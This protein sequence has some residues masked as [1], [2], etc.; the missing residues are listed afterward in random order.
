M[1]DDAEAAEGGGDGGGCCRF[2]WQVLR[3]RWFMISA[4]F[5]VMCGAGTTYL[6][7]V[8]SKDIKVRLGYDQSTLNLL[9]S[10]KDLGSM[11]GIPAGLIAEIIPTWAVLLFGAVLNFSGYFVIWLAVVG[12][13]PKPAVWQM[14]LYICFGANSQNFT[15]TGGIVTC[16]KNFPEGRG[17]MMGLMKG[18]VGLSGALFTQIH[19]ALYGD[20][21]AS[22]ILLVAWLPPALALAFSSTVRPVKSSTHPRERRVFVHYMCVAIALAVFLMALIIAQKQVQF[23]P[24]GYSASA[25]A[26][27]AILL[28]LVGIAVR[29]ELLTRR[30]EK[31]RQNQN[32]REEKKKQNQNQAVQLEPPRTVVMVKDSPDRDRDSPDLPREI[33]VETSCWSCRD[34]RS[35]P[36]RGEDYTILQAILS[37]DMILLFATMSC[38]LGCNLTTLNNLGQIGES[39]GYNKNTIGTTVSLAS[40]WGFFGRV[41]TGFVSESLLKKKF[42]RT[43]FLTIF[44]L[45]SACGNLMIV[46]P[47]PNSLY[48]A[49]L[50]AGFSQGAQL[51]LAFTIISELFGLK[52]YNT[53]YNCGQCSAPLGSYILSVLVVGKLYDKEAMRQLKEKGMTRSMTKELTCIGTQCY[54]M[55]YLVLAATN[56]FAALMS[57]ILVFRTRKFYTGD[58][59][60][61]YRD[62]MKK[63]KKEKEMSVAV[64]VSPPARTD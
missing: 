38:A 8:F 29:E 58:I 53:L 3:G 10:V 40:I 20:D 7:G 30:E 6:F 11:F 34:I 64:S 35:K 46:F 23:S 42:P 15:N 33:K 18:F 14:C 21:S 39:L 24:T 2:V 27:C 57:L 37:T 45:V 60:K 56:V 32:Q 48:I 22:M 62:E 50:V 16:I 59:Y 28:L 49:S 13:I 17:Q 36:N 31:K 55:S 43:L 5:L 41:F 61:R 4:T 19:Y 52:Y 12:K 51:T 54:K 1:G 26:V 9:A 63:N 44:L 25:A 47:F